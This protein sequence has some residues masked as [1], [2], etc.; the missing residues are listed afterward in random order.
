MFVALA[1][2]FVIITLLFYKLTI[3]LQGSV[4]KVIFGIGLIKF[5]IK[6]DQLV[7]TKITK[8]PWHY[9]LGIK[10][11]PKGMLYNIQG[12]KAVAVEYV[13]NGITK[14]V[15]LGT[16]EPEKLEQIIREKL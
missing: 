14:S 16:K 1:I 8:T 6:V 5:Q 3:Q 12:T 10:I 11:T 2:L 7:K 4:I 13:S 9:G 15:L